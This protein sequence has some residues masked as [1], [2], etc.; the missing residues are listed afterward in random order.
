MQVEKNFYW[1]KILIRSYASMKRN[2]D[3]KKKKERKD[4]KRFVI[5]T[6]T[7]EKSER[8][9]KREKEAIFGLLFLIIGKKFYLFKLEEEEEEIF[10][11]QG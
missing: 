8:E 2:V 10:G 5:L 4:L 6:I 1:L 3:W 9:R 7:K 11:R